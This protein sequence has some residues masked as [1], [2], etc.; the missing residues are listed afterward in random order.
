[1][2]LRVVDYDGSCLTLSAPL[3][4]NINH[5]LSAFGGSQFSV[6]ALAGWGL[7]E[8][9]MCELGV[10]ADIVIAGGNV[11]YRAPVFED[12]TCRCELP[13]SWQAFVDRF[14]SRGKASVELTPTVYV[15]NVAAMELGGTYVVIARESNTQ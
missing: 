5:Q 7:L 1:M 4:N 15:Q 12:F 8:L 13:G 6:A 14:S 9:K 3:S 10:E 11:R 2:G